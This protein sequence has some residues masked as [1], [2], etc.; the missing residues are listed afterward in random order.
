[1]ASALESA[2]GN[3]GFA[4]TSIQFQQHHQVFEGPTPHPDVLE[5]YDALVPGTAQRLIDLAVEESHHRRTLESQAQAANI[6]AMN[7]QL[8]LAGDQ[9]KAVFRSDVIGQV[10]GVFV[11]L[12]C[13]GGAVSL[14]VV[15]RELAAAAL[16]A[17]P[18]AAVIQAFFSKRPSPAQPP[19]GAKRP[20]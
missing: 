16:A 9:S 11:A 6:E 15:G 8:T 3:Q 2:M 20:E 1:M 14:A 7:R 18:T 17:I 12:C 19:Q 13:I 4:G 10:A 5:R